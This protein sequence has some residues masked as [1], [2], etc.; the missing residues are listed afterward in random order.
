MAELCELHFN[1]SL[2]R[3][4]R[5][6][7]SVRMDRHLVIRLVGVGP[8]GPTLAVFVWPVLDTL[9]DTLSSLR[10]TLDSY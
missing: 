6:P 7:V 8:V 1:I 4:K 9:G 5:W 2:T 3:S 10:N